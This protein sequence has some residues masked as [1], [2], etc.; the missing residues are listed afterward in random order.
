MWTVLAL[1][2]WVRTKAG[3]RINNKPKLIINLEMLDLIPMTDNLTP[4]VLQ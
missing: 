3:S 2:L 1:H 4:R